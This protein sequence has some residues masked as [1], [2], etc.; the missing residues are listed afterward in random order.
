M[1]CVTLDVGDAV[2]NDHVRQAAAVPECARPD[3]G[4]VFA[5]G[6]VTQVGTIVEC[7]M[8]DTSNFN[9]HT[10]GFERVGIIKTTKF[11]DIFIITHE[12]ISRFRVNCLTN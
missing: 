3:A 2:G 12:R 6:R 7:V 4:D 5:D 1:E 8:L 9:A 10:N 11:I